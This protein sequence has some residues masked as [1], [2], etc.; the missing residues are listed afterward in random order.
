[1]ITLIS[2]VAVSSLFN[3][4][5]GDDV[6]NSQTLHVSVDITAGAYAWASYGEGRQDRLTQRMGKVQTYGGGLGYERNGFFVEVGY[7]DQKFDSDPRVAREVAYHMFTADF[8]TP[9]FAENW[10]Q[11][12]YKHEPEGDISFRIGYE[13]SFTKSISGIIS[14]QHFKPSEYWRTFNP[15]FLVD[16]AEGGENYPY[17]EGNK[18]VDNSA[19]QIGIKWSF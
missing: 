11:T 16:G 15:D 5:A 8:G 4:A 7:L 17:W 2:A 9:P 10:T 19:L 14:Y 3:F 6:Y 12:D 1:M 18:R 13:H